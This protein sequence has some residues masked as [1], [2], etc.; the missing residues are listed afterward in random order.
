MSPPE[1]HLTSGVCVSLKTTRT[2][3]LTI[4]GFL[5][6]LLV[7]TVRRLNRL[8]HRKPIGR[9]FLQLGA[10]CARCLTNWACLQDILTA[11]NLYSQ[12]NRVQRDFF[13]LA[14]TI[15]EAIILYQLQMVL[16]RMGRYRKERNALAA[17]V[18]SL[19]AEPVQLAGLEGAKG[20]KV[21]RAPKS[22]VPKED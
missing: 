21:M 20:G 11:E 10:H 2:V 12:R 1:L 14:F 6:L 8:Y 5:T 15:F 3:Y 13:I 4:F 18:R 9:C 7:D 16:L 19:G 22:P 17:Q